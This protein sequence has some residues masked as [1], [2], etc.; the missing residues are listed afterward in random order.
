MSASGL[1]LYDI[2][3]LAEKLAREFGTLPYEQFAE[4]AD[5]IESAVMRLLI[6]KEGWSWLP[7]KIKQELVPIDWQAVTGTWDLRSGRH[8]GV[9]PKDLWETIVQKLPEMRRRVDELL[10]S[11]H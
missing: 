7:R 4:D 2:G 10:K 8:V 1:Y 11:R 6:M 5:K 3:K 9:D